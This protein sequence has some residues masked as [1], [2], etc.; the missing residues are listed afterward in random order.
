M[1]FG[2]GPKL[3]E[4]KAGLIG[5]TTASKDTS[6]IP[7]TPSQY[8]RV[9]EALGSLVKSLAGELS[10][11]RTTV[12]NQ[13]NDNTVIT[14]K[15]TKVLD[16]VDKAKKGIG[17]LKNHLA[18]KGWLFDE[19]VISQFKK[20]IAENIDQLMKSQTCRTILKSIL[21]TKTRITPEDILKKTE[22]SIQKQNWDQNIKDWGLTLRNGKESPSI[23][24]TTENLRTIQ[25]KEKELT[26]ELTAS[27]GRDPQ[28][29]SSEL[30]LCKVLIKAYTPRLEMKANY[31]ALFEKGAELG[32]DVLSS[33]QQ[34]HFDT[35]ETLL[36]GVITAIG[37]NPAVKSHIDAMI[38]DPENPL[39]KVIVA[40]GGE[41]AILG[42]KLATSSEGLAIATTLLSV[43]TTD[44][45]GSFIADPI[46][47]ILNNRDA[48]GSAAGK[49]SDLVVRMLNNPESANTLIQLSN[50]KL[51]SADIDFLKSIIP[52][53]K[54]LVTELATSMTTTQTT[55][56]EGPSKLAVLVSKVAS[57]VAAR[58]DV[59]LTRFNGGTLPVESTVSNLLSVV[60]QSMALF[61]ANTVGTPT[62]TDPTPQQPIEKPAIERT[63]GGWFTETL[64]DVTA[65]TLGY[66]AAQTV[67][68]AAKSAVGI[69]DTVHNTVTSSVGYVAGSVSGVVNYVKDGATGVVVTQLA[70]Q[71]ASMI[72]KEIDKAL[73]PKKA[74]SPKVALQL[75]PEKL[76]E[77]M[78]QSVG[79]LSHF[80]ADN[81]QVIDQIGASSLTVLGAAADIIQN[82]EMAAKDK[83]ALLSSTLQTSFAQIGQAISDTGGENAQKVGSVLINAS[84]LLGSSVVQA[85]FEKSKLF[86][87][88]TT[89]RVVDHIQ[90]KSMATAQSA[91]QNYETKHYA[92]QLAGLDSPKGPT[93]QVPSKVAAVIRAEKALDNSAVGGVVGGVLSWIGTD[94]L[95]DPVKLAGQLVQQ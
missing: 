59:E 18:S 53:T 71:G 46:T 89:Q 80:V 1:N 41:N 30:A 90:N 39:R 25:T 34:H 95:R 78:A 85:S 5:K 13:I 51:Q 11:A 24:V 57:H 12:G 7:A 49:I 88:D 3:T 45:L 22:N 75:N 43:G 60:D 67:E 77:F 35:P 29:I 2:I 31:H 42:V 40:A 62:Q 69:V 93:I 84:A 26:D 4:T 19:S 94:S 76:N 15:K 72:D 6:S 91:I 56:S 36:R 58:C 54:E 81:P 8:A 48:L 27:T 32:A 82:P 55:H 63:W 44:L 33:L 73:D 65:Y 70:Q 20:S 79:L 68:T 14:E 21:M 52:D 87:A 86:T 50:G 37:D 66:D 10:P 38:T 74:K 23:R 47:T 83:A 92:T 61:T 17:D 28:T 16:I 64:T 9:K